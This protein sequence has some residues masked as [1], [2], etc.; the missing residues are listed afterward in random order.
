MLFDSIKSLQFLFFILFLKNKMSNN[1]VDLPDAPTQTTKTDNS[2]PTPM[3][4]SAFNKTDYFTSG[5]Q[6]YDKSVLRQNYISRMNYLSETND[7]VKGTSSGGA[8][9]VNCLY[10]VVDPTKKD[11]YACGG[12]KKYKDAYGNGDKYCVLYRDEY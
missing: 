3:I 8:N 5:I 2:T 4:T 7:N 1:N 12:N 11:P 10:N 6:K 9:Y